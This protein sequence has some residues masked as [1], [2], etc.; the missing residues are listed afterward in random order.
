VGKA[1]APINVNGNY[2]VLELSKRTPTPYATAK[3]IV[4]QAVQEVGARA[5]STAI[6]AAERRASVTI[7]PRYGKWHSELAL[8]YPPTIPPTSDVLN[9]SANEAT[10]PTSTSPFSG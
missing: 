8:V 1:T 6:N 7:D 10:V 5:T 4:S 3:P 9:L 2:V